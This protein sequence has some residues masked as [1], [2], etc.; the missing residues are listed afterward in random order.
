MSLKKTI[1]QLVKTTDKSNADIHEFLKNT[2]VDCSRRTVRRY[3]NPVRRALA[4][5][6]PP[7]MAKILLLDIETG[8]MKVYVWRPDPKWIPPVMIEEPVTV[9]SWSAKWLFDSV[10]MSKSVTAEEAVARKDESIL[11]D[12]WN[13]LDK[14]DIVVAHNGRQFDTRILNTRFALAGYSPP[15]PYRLIDTLRMVRTTFSLPS[16][17]LDYIN[18]LFHLTPKQDNEGFGLWRRCLRGEQAALD[19]LQRYNEVDIVALEDCYIEL[20]PWI[21]SH[22]NIALYI[23][24]DQEVCTNCGSSELE[25]RGKYYTPAGRYKAFR[26]ENCG[27]IGRARYSDLSIEE[28][29]RLLLSVAR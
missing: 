3:A 25:W 29:R 10:I 21:R 2:G 16:Y 15:M 9:L 12:V 11:S 7:D 20:R 8:P 13:L 5:E 26:C 18:R 1:E 19:E 22:P 14:A 4:G 24:T 28:K 27:A 17:T 23:D 6:A